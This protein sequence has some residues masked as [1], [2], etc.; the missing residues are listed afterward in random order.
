MWELS[1]KNG[2]EYALTFENGAYVLRSGAPDMVATP[3]GVA[4]LA[5]TH[6]PDEL[7]RVQPMP[8]RADVNLLN[9]LWDRNPNGPRPQSD[10]IWG[11]TPDNVTPFGATGLDPVP[12]PTRGGT[13]PNRRWH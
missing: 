3:R 9:D 4:P 5:H 10:I 1:Q 2:I 11:A 13:K 8:S 12:D 7:G 6:P